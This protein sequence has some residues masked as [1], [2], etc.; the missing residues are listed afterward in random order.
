MRDGMKTSRWIVGAVGAALVGGCG[1]SARPNPRRDLFPPDDQPRATQNIAAAQEA[2]GARTDATLCKQHFDFGALNELGQQ[3]LD[4]MLQAVETS[5][6]LVVYLDLPAGSDMTQA[7]GSVTE[8]LR[9]RGLAESQIHLT[10]GSNPNATGSAADAITALQALQS[11]S[12]AAQPQPSYP[13]TTPTNMP[14][15]APSH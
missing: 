10:D 11:Q 2:A 14:P 13:P 4:R 3:K 6:P 7:R 5:Q 15:T 1:H 8:Y 9:S 12:S